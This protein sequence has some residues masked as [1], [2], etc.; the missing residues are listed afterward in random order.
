MNLKFTILFILLCTTLNIYSQLSDM[1]VIGIE[2]VAQVDDGPVNKFNKKPWALNLFEVIG[3]EKAEVNGVKIVPLQQKNIL[4]P[5]PEDKVY[6]A[7]AGAWERNYAKSI[8]L[9]HPDFNNCTIEYNDYLGDS[10]LEPGMIYK[11]KL[12]IPSIFMIEANSAYNN[13]DFKKAYDLYSNIVSSTNM[14]EE[15]KII[16]KNRLTNIDSLISYTES[17]LK[18]EKAAQIMSGKDRD[19]NLYRSRIYYNRVYTESGLMKAILKV[20]EINKILKID[21]H[22]ED[23]KISKLKKIDSHL[24]SNDLRAKNN[25][26]V[27]Y[28]IIDEKGKKKSGKC[29]LIIIESP[30]KDALVTSPIIVGEPIYKNG[31]I[32]IYTQSELD[33]KNNPLLFTLNHPDFIPFEFRMNDFDDGSVLKPESVYRISLDTPSLVMTMANKKLSQLDLKGALTFFNYNFA[34]GEEQEYAEKCRS[35]LNSPIIKPIISTLET[36]TKE[37]R[38]TEKEYFSII[39]GNKQFDDLEKRKSHL[40]NINKKLETEAAELASYYQTLY[41]NAKNVDIDLKY[42][43][44]LAN[45]FTDIKN[46]VRRLPLIIE[47]QEMEERVSSQK[48]YSKP[49]V[50]SETPTVSLVILDDKNKKVFG[51]NQKVKDGKINFIINTEGTNLFKKGKGKILITTPKILN[52]DKNPYKETELQIRDFIISDYNTRKLN[53]TLVKNK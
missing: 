14:N 36:K 29:S 17:A 24:V 26:A 41:D 30:V 22:K 33:N 6:D 18:Y 12:K 28:E 51:I 11:I 7:Y 16:A 32:W 43:Y 21:S 31:E 38:D 19:R 34:E 44:S 2:K 46:G 42:A 39:T 53:V 9:H 52:N 40:N 47:F 1:T 4:L 20:E 35:F 49:K 23:Y 37:C 50:I 48:S 25:D 27:E 45:E 3:R 15:E 10:P 5:Y 8:T 13:L